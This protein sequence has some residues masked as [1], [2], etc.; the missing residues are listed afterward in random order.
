MELMETYD[1]RIWRWWVMS[2]IICKS[3][4]KIQ[5]RSQEDG[6]KPPFCASVH[7]ELL[8][9][10]SPYYTAA[11][12]GH[13][14]ESRKDLFT[15]ALSASQTRLFV[16]WLY[17]G[18]CEHNLWD[19]HG[20]DDLCALYVFAD[21]T[22]IIAL[23]R[24]IMD[25]LVRRLRSLKNPG[26]MGRLVSQL[27]S[28]SGLRLFF[29][30]EA[31][32]ERSRALRYDNVAE[33]DWEQQGYVAEDF[34]EHFYT[35]LVNGHLRNG[36]KEVGPLSFSNVCNYHEH[37]D[38][39]EWKMT[40]GRN[41]VPRS[42]TKPQLA[43]L[44]D[45]SV[46]DLTKAKGNCQTVFFHSFHYP[47]LC[48][49]LYN[50]SYQSFHAITVDCYGG[51]E[52]MHDMFQK[53]KTKKSKAAQ[54]E[55]WERS[56]WNATNVTEIITS[57]A[58]MIKIVNTEPERNGK[59]L[60][61]S[62]HK[63][64]LC[65]FS[66]YYTAVLK[67][68]FSEAKKDTIEMNLPHYH[69]QD[70]V[71]WLYSGNIITCDSSSLFDLYLFADEKM[72]LAFRRSIM[73]RIIHFQDSIYGFLDAKET[74]P[75]LKS[76]PPSSGLFRYIVDHWVYLES[77]GEDGHDLEDFDDDKQIPR[78]FFYQ[79]LRTY[80]ALDRSG[81][82][83]KSD[84]SIDCLELACNYHEHANHEEWQNSCSS[85]VEDLVTLVNKGPN[86]RYYSEG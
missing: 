81:T 43:Y 19:Q 7:K 31:L 37:E 50:T 74:I 79:A 9:F 1:R 84:A 48:L 60:Q 17:T 13:F 4:D 63:E 54:I 38:G 55:E 11:I 73:N 35:Q 64:L 39:E 75:Y 67:G 86:S 18:R 70:L 20:G 23:R 69:M 61:A 27:P 49:W 66:P 58:D 46:E 33:W 51:A 12:K 77:R 44:M 10:Y 47:I 72:M 29:L 24:S 21:Q 57:S 82:S 71:S 8:C 32:A 62:V 53:Q 16:E 36:G 80:A 83:A 52:E 65:Y 34:P 78:E 30:E 56:T 26:D 40:C 14:S 22:D 41:F 59:I 85:A 42:V 45:P 76:L 3:N 5:L 6:S 2:D 28:R 25:S 15:L 68:G